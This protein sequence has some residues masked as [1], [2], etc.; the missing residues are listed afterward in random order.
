MLWRAVA[1]AERPTE[2]VHRLW[3]PEGLQITRRRPGKRRRGP[4]GKVV[5]RA[6]C[7]NHVRSYDILVDT[8]ALYALADQDDTWHEPV[9]VFLESSAH[10]LIVPLTV[11][12]KVCYLLN[13][14]LGQEAERQ[15]VTALARG[16]LTIEPLLISDV[17]RC[18]QLLDTY[19]DANLG[20]VDAS[21]VAI[22][23]RRHIQQIL[24]TH[25]RDFSLVR[26]ERWPAFELL[27]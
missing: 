12:P 10:S 7:S 9:R 27:P 2:W 26:P 16:E 13:T 4:K 6:E 14:Y 15:F 20:L 3:K 23:E 5:H 17:P 11:L 19:P 25:R 18:V 22:A 1:R 21:I 24:T 8:R